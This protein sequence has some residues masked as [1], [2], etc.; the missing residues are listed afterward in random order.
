M[1]GLFNKTTVIF[2]WLISLLPFQVF[3]Q[4]ANDVIKKLASPSFNGRGYYKNGDGKAADFI[5]Q[6]FIKAG[7]QP[8]KGNYIQPFAFPVNTFPGKMKVKIGKHKLVPGKDYI[9]SPAC[10][11]IKGKFEVHK[12][13][14]PLQTFNMFD[15]GND[16]ILLDKSGLDS[17]GMAAIDS[18]SRNPPP[19]NGVIV[20]EEKKLT[21]SVSVKPNSQAFIRV[22]KS[23]IPDDAKNIELDIESKFISEHKT[24]NVLGMVPGSLYPDSFIVFTAHYDH[25]GRMGKKALFPGANDN[26]SGTAMIIDLARYY[27]QPANRPKCSVLFIAF[28]G[29]EAGLI[30]SRYYTENPILPLEQIGFLINLD[31]MG[32]GVDGVMVVNGELH[33]KEFN[34]LDS[35]NKNQNLV[36]EIGKRGKA[37][38]SDHYYFSE[39]GVPA[40]FLYTQGGSKAYHDIYDVPSAIK[41][42]E[43]EDIKTLLKGFVNELAN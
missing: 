25:L 30:G 4:Y 2:T 33:E 1:N 20:A 3:S 9:V 39:R 31:L 35:L 11:S 7:L 8:V 22:F 6:E 23:A 16:F 18:I 14:F 38:N 24:Q 28:A 32:N 42:E 5:T 27:G 36:K 43:F 12:V 34:I 17:T 29:E 19:V 21:W 41:L 40:F 26:A 15:N 13:T 10:P 37:R